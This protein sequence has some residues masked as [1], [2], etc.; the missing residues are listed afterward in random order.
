M[1]NPPDK[2][3]H[4]IRLSPNGHTYI[5]KQPWCNYQVFRKTQM[6]ISTSARSPGHVTLCFYGLYTYM[7][8]KLTNMKY[9]IITFSPSELTIILVILSAMAMA[10]SIY[11]ILCVLVCVRNKLTKTEFYFPFIFISSLVLVTI[12]G[13][14][15]ASP[16]LL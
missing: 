12:K 10:M 16:K 2:Y 6:P 13:A 7:W 3:L 5:K 15:C 14:I 1:T 4:I 9:V 11:G 8:R